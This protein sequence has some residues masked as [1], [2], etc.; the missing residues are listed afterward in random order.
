MTCIAVFRK[1]HYAGQDLV[2]KRSPSPVLRFLSF[3]F[4][5]NIP[6]TLFARKNPNSHVGSRK[7]EPSKN[8]AY[9]CIFLPI[10]R[11]TKLTIAFHFNDRTN[12]C[13]RNKKI[14][15]KQI[16]SKQNPFFCTRTANAFF[17]LLHVLNWGLKH[18]VGPLGD[19]NYSVP[20]RGGNDY[21]F[22][23]SGGSKN[24]EFEKSWIY[25]T[26]LHMHMLLFFHLSG[27][28]A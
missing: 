23:L 27:S 2:Y 25:R 10:K 7:K 11:W 5:S 20:L 12:S 15:K 9:V 21:R 26:Q 4:T 19:R 3:L 1:F 16:K 8:D 13:S 28:L 18:E 22:E 17:L 24:R 6:K 14:K